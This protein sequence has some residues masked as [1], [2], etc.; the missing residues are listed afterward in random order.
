[1]RL[2]RGSARPPEAK[3]I[4]DRIRGERAGPTSPAR[5]AVLLEPRRGTLHVEGRHLPATA[6]LERGTEIVQGLGREERDRIAMLRS[7]GQFFWLDIS[8]SE[9]RLADLGKALDLPDRP[10]HSP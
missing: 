10:C 5:S 9:T 4:E 7:R 3:P 6:T 1:M 2:P 8:L